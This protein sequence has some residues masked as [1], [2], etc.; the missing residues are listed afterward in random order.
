MA[1]T[2]AGMDAMLNI[3]NATVYLGVHNGAPGASGGTNELAGT[4]PAIGFGS[5]ESDGG[6]GRQRRGPS[7]AA[8][9]FT[10]PGAGTYEAWSIWSA[11]TGGTCYWVIPFDTNRTLLSGDDLRAPQNGITCSVAPAS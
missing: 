2:S 6:S 9:T 11:D 10:N 4:R 8:I 1:V 3:L 7:A 5:A